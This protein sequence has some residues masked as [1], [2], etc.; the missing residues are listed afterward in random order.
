MI[1]ITAVRAVAVLL[2]IA[3][4]GFL[5]IKKKM[6]SEACIPGFSK[7][8]LYVAQP[9]LAVYTFRSSAYSAE[10]L[11]EVGKF[12]LL[13]AAIFAIMIGG[14]YLILRNK[15]KNPI[16]RVMTFAVG[17]ANCAFFGIPIIEAL[18]PE[19]APDVIIFT[20][21]YSLVMNLIGWTVGSAIMAQDVRY[22]SLKKILLNPAMIGTAIALLLFITELP[23]PTDVGNMITT[24]AKMST[25]LSMIIM[26]MRLGTMNLGRMFTNVRVYATIFAK[27]VIMPLIAFLL[28]AFLPMSY[29]VKST[30]FIVCACPVASVT[31]NYAEIVGEGQEEAASMLLVGTMLSIVTLPLLVLLLPLLA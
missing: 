22:I 26:G 12:A 8:L 17:S 2:A 13:S 9:C 1:F 24:T 6:V 16:Y 20:M 11:I 15:Y 10:K 27:Q 30:F 7:V 3:L 5:L 25:P 21:V 14:A 19:I 29:E 23:M 18:M 28:V 31:L 4:P